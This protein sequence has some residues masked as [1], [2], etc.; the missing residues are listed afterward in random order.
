MASKKL[1][2]IIFFITIVAIRFT[3][4]TTYYYYFTMIAKIKSASINGLTGMTV[5]VEV[6]VSKGMPAFN[7]V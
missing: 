2:K 1:G 5:D 4:L 3:F 6:D 7:I